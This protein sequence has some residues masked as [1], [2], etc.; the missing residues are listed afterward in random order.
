VVI[1]RQRAEA[2]DVVIEACTEPHVLL[3]DLC[4]LLDD[5]TAV[6]LVL[7]QPPA[8][9]KRLAC[10]QKLVDKY[11]QVSP[12]EPDSCGIVRAIRLSKAPAMRAPLPSR[13]HPVTAIFFV[14]IF[15]L[16]I[17]SRASMIRL[18]PHVHA[19]MA[20]AVALAP[21]SSKKRPTPRLAGFEFC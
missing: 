3:D 8:C 15:A 10:L 7:G 21:Y 2:V 12:P 14:L 6:L 18:M 16:D 17:I 4:R 13:E 20:E 19:V 11:A 5:V 1:V 9:T